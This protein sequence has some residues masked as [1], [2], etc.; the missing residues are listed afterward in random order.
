MEKGRPG[1]RTTE[2]IAAHWFNQLKPL[3]RPVY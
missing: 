3:A 1:R 2:A